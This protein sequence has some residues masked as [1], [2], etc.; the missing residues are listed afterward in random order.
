MPFPAK[1]APRGDCTAVTGGFDLPTWNSLGGSVQNRMYLGASSGVQPRGTA[2]ARAL[3]LAMLSSLCVP[4][5]GEAQTKVLYGNDF[6]VPNVPPDITCGDALDWRGINKLYGSE[7]FNFEQEFSVEAIHLHSPLDL[8]QNVGESHG[9][10]AIGMLSSRQDDKLALTL[11]TQGATFLNLGLDLSSIDVRGCGGP[12]GV[13]VPELHITLV[14]SPSGRFAWPDEHT[15]LDEVTFVGEAAPDPWTFAWTSH[16]DGLDAS[17]A[18]GEYV[19]VIFDLIRSGYAAFDNL[20]ITASETSGVIDQDLDGVADDADDAPTD[21][22]QC[23]DSDQD[24][25]DDCDPAVRPADTP[26]EERAHLTPPSPPE[27]ESNDEPESDS[28]TGDDS[29]QGAE[30]QADNPAQA[31]TVAAPQDKDSDL[32]EAVA[33]G[34]QCTTLQVRHD[35]PLTVG[36][37]SWLSGSAL[38]FFRRHRNRRQRQ[39]KTASR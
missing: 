8:Y 17:A 27:P 36:L 14:D 9:N 29:A 18:T 21:P 37:A 4:A 3:W 7:S 39:G 31:G 10:F 15:V 13:D 6:E 25:A 1:L 5:S 23:G 24:G 32:E 19:T 22:G 38:L 28:E 26:Y 12:F 34:C 35:R 30:S 16:V 11:K 33:S 20:S 2:A